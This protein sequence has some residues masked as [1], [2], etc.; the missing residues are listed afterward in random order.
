MLFLHQP[1]ETHGETA[2]HPLFHQDKSQDIEMILDLVSLGIQHKIL[3]LPHPVLTLSPHFF[4]LP[5]LR[6]WYCHHSHH[7]SLLFVSCCFH[8]LLPHLLPHD[9]LFLSYYLLLLYSFVRPLATNVVKTMLN[10]FD[11]H[12]IFRY[13]CQYFFDDEAPQ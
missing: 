3:D 7:Y 11:Y 4:L 1:L 8:F 12:L 13:I 2:T 6:Y 10:F 5:W 9:P